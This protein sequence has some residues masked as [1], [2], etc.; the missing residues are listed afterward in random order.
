MGGTGSQ[1]LIAY[2]TP[3]R[4]KGKIVGIAALF[5]RASAMWAIVHEGHGAG[6]EGSFAVV[7]GP[8]GAGLAHSFDDAAVFHPAGP[9]HD[10][11]SPAL[12]PEPRSGTHTG[13][14]PEGADP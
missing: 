4:W 3:V 5:A 9:L 10:A 13:A 11:E 14:L 7:L 2:A 8:Y 12:G 1:A 6:G